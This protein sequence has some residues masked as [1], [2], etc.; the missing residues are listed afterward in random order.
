[1]SPRSLRWILPFAILPTITCSE[2]TRPDPTS[3]R[4]LIGPLCQLG[5]V[6]T[7]PNPSAPGVFLGSGVTPMQ[8]FGDMQT[9]ADA[10]G[11]GDFCEKSLAAAFAPE[12]KY[13]SADNVG[14]EP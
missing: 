8:C 13:Y 1:M 2:A 7:D 3:P 14:R 5:C 4:A 6:E 10:D 9:D 11:M 12:L